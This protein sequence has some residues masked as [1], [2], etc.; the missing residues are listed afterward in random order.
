MHRPRIPLTGTE[1]LRAEHT[2]P[3]FIAILAGGKSTRM[4]S[5][6]AFLAYRGNSFISQVAA[7][8]TRVCD[9]VLVIIGEKDKRRFEA[10]LGREMG[11]ANDAY[12]LGAPLGGMMTAFDIFEDGYAAVV[13]CD[14]P[15]VKGEVLE[16]LRDS[17]VS[18]SAAVPVWESGKIEPLC[19][20]YEVKEARR[21]SL[22]AV[23]SGRIRVRDMIALLD[24]V[25]Y[26]P[27]SRLRTVDPTLDSLVNVN[28]PDDLGALE[29]KSHP[30]GALL[31]AP[32]GLPADE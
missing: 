2:R 7:E 1:R 3:F 10:D 19:S 29:Q 12:H 9:D 25:N 28:T 15:L 11:I 18:H 8:A 5:D 23:E 16:T 32:A 31:R 22:R 13:A 24:D 26:V 4:K 27:V 17:A 14:S 21:A 20:V 30:E 6:K